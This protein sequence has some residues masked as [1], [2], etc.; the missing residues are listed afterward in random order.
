MTKKVINQNTKLDVELINSIESKYIFSKNP[1]NRIIKKMFEEVT[2][3]DKKLAL[4]NLSKKISSIENCDLKKNAKQIVLGC[5]NINSPLML[6]GGT[7][8]VQEDISGLPFEG[9]VGNLLKKMLSAININDEN[10]YLSYAINFRPPNDRK[11]TSAEIKRYSNFLQEHISII[12]PKIIVL[13]GST[14]MEALTGLN[15]KI[16]NERG[17]WKDII[18]KNTS[19]PLLITFSPS[20][21]LRYP[22][23]KKY[24]WEDLKKINQKIQNLK[25]KI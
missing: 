1:I 3:L 8:N 10:V 17:K 16:S 14:A 11:P 24:S 2:Q 19:L 20:Y 13:M 6:I 12:N 9:E 18:I 7:P 15:N 23:N 5:G 4:S 21:L 25:I 22:E